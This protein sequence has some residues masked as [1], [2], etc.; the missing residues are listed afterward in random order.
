MNMSSGTTTS[1]KRTIDATAQ[2]PLT[3]FCP[4]YHQAIELV[5]RRWTGAIL[6]VLLTGRH[7]FTEIVDAIPGVSD[8][9]IAER[10]RELEAAHVVKRRVITGPPVRVDYELTLQGQELQ[11]AIVAVA[12]WAEKWLPLQEATRA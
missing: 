4:R 5:G 8:R 10:L 3:A 2:E 1:S 11:S 6:R 7:R 9:L 12:L